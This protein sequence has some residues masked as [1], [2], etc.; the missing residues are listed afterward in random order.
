MFGSQIEHGTG[1]LNQHGTGQLAKKLYSMKP[2][3]KLLYLGQEMNFQLCPRQ[4]TNYLL[5]TY[6]TLSSPR[7]SLQ[8]SSSCN[9]FPI[10]IL[11]NTLFI[12]FSRFIQLT[13]IIFNQTST[14]VTHFFPLHISIEYKAE[15][16]SNHHL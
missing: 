3:Y 16:S 7:K 11:F 12:F 8:P 4:Y 5:L 13:V 9:F 2:W 10:S 1:Q 14:K 15:D 6:Y